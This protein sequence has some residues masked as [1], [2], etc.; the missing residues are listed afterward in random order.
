MYPLVVGQK[1]MKAVEY[2][3]ALPIFGK[4]LNQFHSVEDENGFM[5]NKEPIPVLHGCRQ[6]VMW[7]LG[8]SLSVLAPDVKVHFRT[9]IAIVDC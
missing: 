7:A 6:E 8:E 4:Y 3:G 2:I 5:L 1:G 9:K